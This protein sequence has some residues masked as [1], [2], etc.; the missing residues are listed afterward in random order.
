MTDLITETRSYQANTQ[1]MQMAK[2]LYSKTFEV[3]K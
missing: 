3:L 2:S 1:A